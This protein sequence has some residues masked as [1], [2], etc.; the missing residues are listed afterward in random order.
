MFVT[1]SHDVYD[2]P[3]A[4]LLQQVFTTLVEEGQLCL[5]V[6]L[7]LNTSLHS[8]TFLCSPP[9]LPFPSPLPSPYSLPLLPS[10]HPPPPFLPPLLIPPLLRLPTTITLGIP[11]ILQ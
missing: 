8:L 6:P 10:L 4:S 2:E 7:F 5:T 9:S 1:Y 11:S 3:G